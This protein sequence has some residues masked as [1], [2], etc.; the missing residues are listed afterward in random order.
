MIGV[1]NWNIYLKKNFQ[2]RK[3]EDESRRK[4]CL[5]VRKKKRTTFWNNQKMST[6]E[7]IEG[8]ILWIVNRDTL[9]NRLIDLLSKMEKISRSKRKIF[10]NKKKGEKRK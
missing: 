2:G 3:V 10:E 1:W 6:F 9:T 8:K 5:E 4:K 7:K